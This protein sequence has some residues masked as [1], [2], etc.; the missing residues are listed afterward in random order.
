M[1]GIT[2]QIT[3]LTLNATAGTYNASTRQNR[4]AIYPLSQAA[5]DRF[6]KVEA[7]AYIK[8]ELPRQIKPMLYKAGFIY[9]ADLYSKPTYSLNGSRTQIAALIRI[10]FEDTNNEG[11]TEFT[12]K[13]F[14]TGLLNSGK[15]VKQYG[16]I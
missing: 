16:T 15:I 11:K 14:R 13:V 2:I 9:G 3:A 1:K 12:K 4:S 8:N 6:K 5:I 10:T 7:P